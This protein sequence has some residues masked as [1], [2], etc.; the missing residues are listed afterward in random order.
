MKFIHEQNK[1]YVKDENDKVI[2]LATFPFVEENVINVDHTF[3]DPS[4]RGQGIASKLMNEVYNHAK[5]KCYKVIN[6]CPYA[7]AWFNK[8]ADKCDVLSPK[9]SKNVA[10]KI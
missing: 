4:L 7:V 2:V 6:T 9:S 1:I 8:N 3:V 10:C 5:E